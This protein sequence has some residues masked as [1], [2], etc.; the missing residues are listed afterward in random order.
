[1][2]QIHKIAETSNYLDQVINNNNIYF[3]IYLSKEYID[4]S[5]NIGRS[6]MMSATILL[7]SNALNKQT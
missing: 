7:L 1:M 3:Q 2:G 5:S 6:K 4:K